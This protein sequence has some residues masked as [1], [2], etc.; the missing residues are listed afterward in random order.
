MNG[1]IG[2]E[3]TPEGRLAAVAKTLMVKMEE[4]YRHN[5]VGPK[6]PDY[7]D[8]REAF[9]PFIQR[10]LLRAR[11]EEARKLG[12]RTITERVKELAKELH[13]IKIPEGFE[14]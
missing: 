6:E 11:I 2:A 9:R 8:F 7:A 3:D 12:G 14:L 13:A 10:E 1:R 5:R 4:Q